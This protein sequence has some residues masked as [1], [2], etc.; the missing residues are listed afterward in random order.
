MS[1]QYC[2]H[3]CEPIQQEILII[4]IYPKVKHNFFQNLIF[5]FCSNH[6]NKLD[7]NICNSESLNVFKKTLLNFIRPFGWTVF[8]CHNPKVVKLLTRLRLGLSHLNKPKLKHSFQDSLN[9]ICTCGNDIET[10]AHFRL[11]CSNFS[12]KR[13]N[14]PEY[15]RNHQYKNFNKKQFWNYRNHFLRR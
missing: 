12:N 2:S 6:R 1:V 14:F 7:L 13:S 15:H 3:F 8:N 9:S 4:L 5:S 11:P 10:S